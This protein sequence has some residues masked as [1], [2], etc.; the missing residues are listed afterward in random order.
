MADLNK[1]KRKLDGMEIS[2]LLKYVQEKYPENA[3]LGI[4]SKKS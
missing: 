1:L 4:G 2:E 3:E